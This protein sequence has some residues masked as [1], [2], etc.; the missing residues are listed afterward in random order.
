MPRCR[1]WENDLSLFQV[2]KFV[3]PLSVLLVKD[4]KLTGR[5]GTDWD[6]R[7]TLAAILLAGL[8]PL[9]WAVTTLPQP[10][11]ATQSAEPATTQDQTTNQAQSG[12]KPSANSETSSSPVASTPPAKVSKGDVSHTTTRKK[13]AHKKKAVP[14]DCN[15]LSGSAKSASGTTTKKSGSEAGSSQSAPAGTSSPCP[16]PKVIVRQGGTSQPSVQVAGGAPGS[17]TSQQRNTAN[18]MLDVA[19]GNLKKIAGR[20]LSSQQ[21]EMVSQI[22]QFMD[23]SKASVVDGDV[24]RARTLAWKAQLLS[25]ELVKPEQ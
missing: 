16:P 14:G 8:V 2:G 11:A 10:A 9:P 23:Q 17:Q 20:Q 22:H 24:D 13:T 18:E 15:S 21:Q 25:E 5:V 7:M 3:T 12:S 4:V 1:H 19:E 6:L